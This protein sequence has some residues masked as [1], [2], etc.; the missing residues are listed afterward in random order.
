[1]L[2]IT[3]RSFVGTLPAAVPVLNANDRIRVALIGVG[4]RGRGDRR[5]DH[6]QSRHQGD[7]RGQRPPP[8]R[9]ASSDSAH[10]DPPS[11]R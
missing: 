6:E 4:G 10:A 8:A 2:P 9:P 11:R 5:G 1:M 7:H 3:R